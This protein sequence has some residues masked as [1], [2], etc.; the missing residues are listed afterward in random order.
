MLFVSQRGGHGLGHDYCVNSN[1]VIRYMEKKG[2]EEKNK[3]K[4]VNM[5]GTQTPR[6]RLTFGPAV[7]KVYG[8]GLYT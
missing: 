6:G 8:N 1:T 3:Y 2:R 4:H 5:R 7:P